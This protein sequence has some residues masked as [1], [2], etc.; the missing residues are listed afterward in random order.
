MMDHVE[1]HLSGRAKEERMDCMHP[2]CK[3]KGVVLIYVMHS[4]NHV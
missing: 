4:D 3:V 2:I 1:T